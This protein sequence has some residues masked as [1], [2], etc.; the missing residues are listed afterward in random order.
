M[1]CDSVMAKYYNKEY[2]LRILKLVHAKLFDQAIYE[3]QKYL[4]KYPNDCCGHAYYADA[5]IKSGRIEEARE[6]LDNVVVLPSTPKQS[7]DDLVIFNIKLL[8]CEERYSE[9]LEL[10]MDN[11][12]IF[13]KRDL[14]HLEILMFL[15]KK[16]NLLGD[17]DYSGYN[18]KVDQITA[19]S[20]ENVLSCIKNC[21]LNPLREGHLVFNDNFMLE[22]V[23][24]KLRTLLPCDGAIRDNIL[25]C[26]YVFKYECCGKVNGKN[27]DYIEVVALQNSND[28]LM[29]YPYE[30]K[31]KMSCMDL[32]PKHEEPAKLKRLSQIDKFNQRYNK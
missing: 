21:R 5:L 26:S 7:L 17:V 14:P 6:V 12:N 9:C 13:E 3:Y 32:T 10:F 20:E 15:K 24:Y 22:D 4:E 19:Y 28:I 18:Y 2:F 8:C 27:V 25:E 23:Y 30:N 31:E 1:G 29:I 11:I 16:L